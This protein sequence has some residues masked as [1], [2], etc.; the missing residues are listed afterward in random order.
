V[1]RVWAKLFGAGIVR[2]V[3][4]FGTTGEA[5][6]H[7][8]LLDFLARRFMADAWSTKALV[9]SL[10]LSRVY[11][12]AAA[13]PPRAAAADP[14]NRLL[15][16]TNRRRLDAEALRDAILQVSGTLDLA[17][18]G[19]GIADPNVLGGAGGDR[20]TEYGY[21]FTDTRRSVYTPAFRN[22]RLE[23][24]EAFD[25]AD[26]NAV[27]G[28]RAESTVAPQALYLLN[29]PFVMEQAELAAAKLL[30]TG[31]ADDEARV[32]AAFLAAVGRRPRPAEREAV[33]ASLTAAGTEPAAGW[34]RVF[35]ALSG[36]ID[37]RTL[38]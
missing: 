25:A 36:C 29:S 35:Q 28:A 26:P 23:L 7:P 30:A 10:V 13:S 19:P 11:R 32:D 6:T 20:P 1:N 15:S 18:G 34:Q 14:E 16:H 4:N 3:D 24:F 21:Q 37:F 22:R 2:T 5:P 38:E 33:I 8:E 12:L 17:A 9:R 31:P 27:A